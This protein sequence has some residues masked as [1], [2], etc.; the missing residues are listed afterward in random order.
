MLARLL[1]TIVISL[2]YSH[3][4]HIFLFILKLKMRRKD[5]KRQWPCNLASCGHNRHRN[6]HFFN[7]NLIWLST[8]FCQFSW[9]I[10]EDVFGFLLWLGILCCMWCM[11][12][13]RYKIWKFWIQYWIQVGSCGID[14]PRSLYDD[15]L[16]LCVVE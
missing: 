15:S 9:E 16:L 14:P 10:F 3:F 6:A 13:H 5:N 7:I 8:G 1:H 2:T 4:V 12:I 11:G